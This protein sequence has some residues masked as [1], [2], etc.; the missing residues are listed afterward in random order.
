MTSKKYMKKKTKAKAKCNKSK[1]RQTD[2]CDKSVSCTTLPETLLRKKSNFPCLSEINIDFFNIMNTIYQNGPTVWTW[3]RAFEIY[4]SYN[5]GHNKSF[6]SK[7]YAY[8]CKNNN[9]SNYGDHRKFISNV[10]DEYT[11]NISFRLM[12]ENIE[13]Y[14]DC[15]HSFMMPAN[16]HENK[17]LSK[18]VTSDNLLENLFKSTFERIL[19]SIIKSTYH[20]FTKAANTNIHISGGRIDSNILLSVKAG[21]YEALQLFKLNYME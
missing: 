2:N 20:N 5:S 14:Y 3:S 1:H 15:L 13:K 18:I 21:C 19:I 12:K 4:N 17:V 11:F 7:I 6:N 9:Y 8:V 16:L 10:M